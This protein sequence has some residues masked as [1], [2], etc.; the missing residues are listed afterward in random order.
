MLSMQVR[1]SV[2]QEEIIDVVGIKQQVDLIIRRK[3]DEISPKQ[4]KQVRYCRYES[5][6]RHII[7]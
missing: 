4:I 2:S 7:K 3:M 1:K 6:Y 5:F